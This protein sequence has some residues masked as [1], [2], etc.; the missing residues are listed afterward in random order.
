MAAA[1]ED[2]AAE[3]MVGMIG[4]TIG[5]DVGNTIEAEGTTT[6]EETESTMVETTTTDDVMITKIL[7]LHNRHLVATSELPV[8]EN[9]LLRLLLLQRSHR[10]ISSI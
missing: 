4:D 9:R 2:E 5:V 6:V 7:A 3:I 10:W 1:T 8:E